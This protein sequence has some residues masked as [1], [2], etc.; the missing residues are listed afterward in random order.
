MYD[1]GRD[2]ADEEG[3][4]RA[5][6]ASEDEER[7]WANAAFVVRARRMAFVRKVLL[8][9]G[10]QLLFCAAMTAGAVFSG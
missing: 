10:I 4:G 9:V 1:E 6:A 5:R 2:Y 8:V 7:P 3:Q